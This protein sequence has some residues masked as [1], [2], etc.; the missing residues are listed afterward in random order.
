MTKKSDSGQGPGEK[1]FE[2]LFSLGKSN[3]RFEVFADGLIASRAN[4]ERLLSDVQLL[5][6][7]GCLSSAKILLTT[8]REEIAKSYVITDMCRL[9]PTEH[10]SVL[11]TLCRAFYDHINKHAYLKV[12]DYQNL[13]SMADANAIWRIEIKRLWPGSCEAGEPDMPHDTYFD[14]EFP[15]YIDYNNYTRG[16]SVPQN[17]SQKPYFEGVFSEKPITTTSNLI[18]SWSD[19]ASIGLCSGKVLGILNSVFKKHYIGE[20]VT[21]AELVRLYEKVGKRIAEDTGIA[22]ESFVS[23]PLA[24]WPLYHFVSGNG[25]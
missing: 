23:S 9:D 5:V 20:A 12:L 24:E 13:H 3:E 10:N 6:K 17:V 7:E 16:W 2:N 18:Q 19:A 8:A 15:L 11:R 14:R 25:G 1:L 21:R 22:V 4:A